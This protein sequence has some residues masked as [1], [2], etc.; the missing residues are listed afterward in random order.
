M[1]FSNHCSNAVF[2]NASP[3]LTVRFFG[4]EHRGFLTEGVKNYQIAPMSPLNSPTFF[5][6]TSIVYAYTRSLDVQT[7]IV[8]E[9]IDHLHIYFVCVQINFEFIHKAITPDICKLS[10]DFL[11]AFEVFL[12]LKSELSSESQ[13]VPSGTLTTNYGYSLLDLFVFLTS[14]GPTAVLLRLVQVL[15]RRTRRIGTTPQQLKPGFFAC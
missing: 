6:C 14:L 2:S 1:T 4:G 3:G 15:S 9:L 10:H 5:V 11:P 13:Y 12:T 8:F 7:E